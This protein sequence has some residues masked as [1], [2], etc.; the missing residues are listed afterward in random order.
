MAEEDLEVYVCLNVDCKSRGSE[1]VLE[2]LNARLA[3]AGLDH[4]L[5]EPYLC[6][7][8]CQ[9]G[10]NVVIPAKRRWFSGVSAEDVEAI[11][12]FLQ[13]GEPPARLTQKNDPKLEKFIFDIFDAGRLPGRGD[14]FR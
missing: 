13:G 2:R 10:P 12:A 14:F 9:R 5:P 3:E 11:I 6:F 4:V 8:A 7:S 1:Q